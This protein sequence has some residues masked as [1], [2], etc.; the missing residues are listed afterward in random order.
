MN[1]TKQNEVVITFDE[2]KNG[3]AIAEVNSG[4]IMIDKSRFYPCVEN[5]ENLDFIN[6]CLKTLADSIAPE[7]LCTPQFTL[8]I[9]P[10][11]IGGEFITVPSVNKAKVGEA[12]KTEMK[13]LYR[14]YDELE[15]KTELIFSNKVKQIFFVSFINQKYLKDIHKCC[16]S[17]RI[18]PK[19]IISSAVALASASLYFK[20]KLK[21]EN[22]IILNIKNFSSTI[23]VLI[24]G[25]IFGGVELNYGLNVLSSKK[26]VRDG[27][28]NP[29]DIASS[30]LLEMDNL[31]IDMRRFKNQKNVE[32]SVKNSNR[33]IFIRQ[34]E[35]IKYCIDEV[36]LPKLDTAFIISPELIE[37]DDNDLLISPLFN[38]EEMKL[39][40]CENFQNLGA[41][42]IQRNLK[43]QIF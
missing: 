41:I 11:F 25:K 10:R 9:P 18:F 27:E 37:N 24:Q 39:D 36:D 31:N 29:H 30:F 34:L 35:N 1:F 17:L 22:A 20:P 21:K 38:L 33:N 43:N 5:S 28:L 40:I 7:P 26:N 8:I 32:S 14:N 2:V 23:C 13:N 16:S 3:V 42:N 4:H 15:I 6:L 19:N 12:I